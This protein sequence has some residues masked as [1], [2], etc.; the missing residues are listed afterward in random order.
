MGLIVD[1]MAWQV[2]TDDYT[3][4]KFQTILRFHCLFVVII[5]MLPYFRLGIY[6]FVININNGVCDHRQFIY[7]PVHISVTI[8]T[9]LMAT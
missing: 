8:K 3:D 2:V 4:E 6:E 5:E 1:M 7:E 9:C